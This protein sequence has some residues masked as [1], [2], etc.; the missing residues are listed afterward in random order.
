MTDAATATARRE[1]ARW[2]A[3]RAD[4]LDPARDPAFQR[5]LAAHA[6]HAAAWAEAD[7]AWAAVTQPRR[8]GESALLRNRIA[9]HRDLRRAR[10][11]RLVVSTGFAAAAAVV[12]AFLL[13]ARN[14]PVAA[15]S[16]ARIVVR[17]HVQTLADGSRVELNA[18]AE[19]AVDFTP[20]LRSVR[21]VRGEALFTVAKNPA[22]PFVVT[23]GTVQVRAVGTA[24][25]V[26]LA[27][28]G[29]DVLVT[30]G[31]VAVNPSATEFPA[32]SD[33]AA[34]AVARATPGASLVFVDAGAQTRVLLPSSAGV[35]GA[36]SAPAPAITPLT[37]AAIATAL[38]WRGRR[39]EFTE[40]PLGETLTWFNRQN[41]LRLS[42]ATPALAQ[43]RINGAYWMDDPEGFARLVSATLGFRIERKDG[44]IVLHG[45]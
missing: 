31:R 39:V 38:A 32:H 35:A 27:P 41:A 7:A 28:A 22:R 18:G 5:W 29:V 44:E 9:A 45:K 34:V 14:S 19:I 2:I 23:A 30:E 25:N 8:D 43:R 12:V 40:T 24:F 16:V 4:G 42:L 26:R 3:R 37:P 36:A 15:P 20:G 21:L 17:P 1:A 6:G 33:H 13:P 11:R 10:L